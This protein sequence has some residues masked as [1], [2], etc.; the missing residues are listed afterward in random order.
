AS[1][2]DLRRQTRRLPGQV[3]SYRNLHSLVGGDLSPKTRVQ[4]LKIFVGIPDA[5]PDKSGPTEI[6]AIW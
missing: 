3:R 1:A 6:C 2:E 4:A 5:F